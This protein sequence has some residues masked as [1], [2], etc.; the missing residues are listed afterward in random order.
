LTSLV[1]RVVGPGR[2]EVRVNTEIN[3]KKVQLHEENYDPF[4]KVPRSKQVRSRVDGNAGGVGG[5]AGAAANVPSSESGEGAQGPGGSGARVKEE[6]VNYEI[7]KTVR[8]TIKPGGGIERLSVAVLVDGNYQTVDGQQEF[9]PRG[10][11]QLD[12]LRSLVA[13]AAGISQERGDTITVE[14]MPLHAPE[15]SSRAVGELSW[16]EIGMEAARY[17]G[18]VLVTFLILWF[19]GRPLMRYLT[20]PHSGTVRE[21]PYLEAAGMEGE[22]GAAT[23]PERD[24][25]RRELEQRRQEIEER[26]ATENE[27]QEQVREVVRNEQ[28]NAV[29]VIRQ[30]LRE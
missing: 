21:S 25:E 28:E 4:S 14:S 30:W 15:Q 24:E 20:E 9:V 16:W 13:N 19:V 12:S 8:D 10:P 27:R 23:L 18:Y 22:G 2:A 11:E 5:E 7:S 17:A 6:V 29:G 1:E 3:D 26:S